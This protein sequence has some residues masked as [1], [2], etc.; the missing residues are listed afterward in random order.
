MKTFSDKGELRGFLPAGPLL[1]NDQ[2]KFSEQNG[3]RRLSTPG[4]KKYWNGGKQE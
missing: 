3:N 4:R 1:K 2:R